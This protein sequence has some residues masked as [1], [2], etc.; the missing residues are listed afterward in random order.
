M[1]DNEERLLKCLDKMQVRG[2]SGLLSHR[3]VA[4][5]VRPLCLHSLFPVWLVC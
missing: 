2:F 5:S 3:S 4:S 1:A